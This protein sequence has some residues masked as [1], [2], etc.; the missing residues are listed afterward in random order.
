MNA[1]MQQPE[2]RY[3]VLDAAPRRLRD[4]LLRWEVILVILLA[5]TIVVNTIV[6]PYFLDVFNLADATFNFSEKAIIALAMALLILVRQIDLSVAAIV[7]LAAMGIGYAAEAG[8]GPAALFATGI[9][10]G[11]LCGVFNGVLVTWFALPSIVVT[12]GTMSLF[13]GLTQVILGDQAK[14]KYPPEF[15][16]LGQ[17]YFVKMKETG[18][19]WLSVPP[20][21]LSFLVFLVLAVLFGIVLHKTA[22]GRKLFAIGSNPVAA[23]FSGIP[24]DRLTFLLFMVSGALSGLA[25][26]LLTARLGS[27]RSNIAIGWELDIVTMVILGGVSIAG[28]V[29]SIVGV[30]L[31]VFVLGLVTFGMSLNNIPGQVVSVYIGLLLIAVIAIPRIVDKLGF[32]T[33]R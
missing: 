28:G 11:L 4:V 9:G 17:S 5:L 26:A 21:P 3:T 7:A 29:G 1:P 23:R 13:R 22:M 24:V 31:A 8:F 14:T 2:S 16:E 27:M 20:L 25:A 10:I 33:G 15:L 18:I 32:R 6:S 12:I 30:V 19:P